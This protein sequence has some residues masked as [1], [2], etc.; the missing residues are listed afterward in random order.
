M[1]RQLA[2]VFA[3]MSIGVAEAQDTAAT[4]AQGAVP[5]Q[6]GIEDARPAP[7]AAPPAPAGLEGYDPSETFEGAVDLS[8]TGAPG[9]LFAAGGPVIWILTLLAVLG[10]AVALVK[11]AQFLL[12]GVGRT[13]FV[14][15]T[16]RT[17]RAG[18]SEEALE[19][20]DG[21]RAPV[22]RVMA[23]ALRGKL[24]PE[25][26]DAL[27]REETARV[28]QANL[29]GLERGLALLRLIAETA[30]LLGL[31]GTVLGMIDA[32]QQMQAAGERVE[33]GLLAG[34][35]WEALLTTAAGLGVAI[36]AAA[37]HTWLQ[38]AVEVETQHMEDAAT[39]TFTLPLYPK[40]K[41]R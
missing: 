24:D 34:G 11:G 27:V 1:V 13:G 19:T 9:N 22:A 5:D 25:M 39:Q 6:A 2:L 28:A 33:P 15:P 36:P 41:P 23:A 10:L 30:P 16:V 35:I 40:G 21:A 12:A 20:L 32:F 29:D 31:L 38:R 26:D 18:G 17:I 37:L 4:A 14:A 8:V 7:E 3:A